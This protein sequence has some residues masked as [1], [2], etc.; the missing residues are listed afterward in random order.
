[1]GLG[2]I[3]RALS[4]APMSSTPE[5]IEEWERSSLLTYS[6]HRRSAADCARE[7]AQIDD[8]FLR[9][10][11]SLGTHGS[12]P[13]A[14]RGDAGQSGSLAAR[15]LARHGASLLRSGD[16]P[17][18]V[19]VFRQAA[20]I[21]PGSAAAW[22]NLGVA[23]DCAGDPGEA[24]T[25]L[26]RSLGLLQAQPASWLQ[27]GLVREKL[28]DPHGAEFAF[29]RALEL[30]PLDPASWQCLALLKTAQGDIPAAIDCYTASVDRGGAGPAVWANL[31]KLCHRIGRFAESHDAYAKAA[32]LE[33]GNEVFRAMERKTAFLHGLLRG[34]TPDEALKA[35]CGTA[36]PRGS[37][38]EAQA[39]SIL[40]T[41][42]GILNGFGHSG[43]ARAAARK[44]LSL[45]PDDTTMRYLADALE[46][47]GPLRSPPDYLV[48]H[49]D[50]FAEHFDAQLVG[51][52]GYDLP[53]QIGSLLGAL[54]AGLRAAHAL[55]A[56]CGTGLCGPI[57]RPFAARLTGVDLSAG[58][59]A[60]AARRGVY[61]ALVQSELLAFLN[62]TPH[63]Y[64]L[65]AAA[66]VL[67]YFGDLTPLFTMAAYALR[68]G[69]LFIAST[70]QTSDGDFRLRSSGRFGHAPGYVQRTARP[71]FIAE[72]V[73][74]TTLRLEGK[75]R[76]AGHLFVFRRL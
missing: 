49:F 42:F 39:R 68:P 7:H 71:E 16:A 48:E 58:M 1:M 70:E 6:A 14:A 51:T 23:L 28:L 31:G 27:L 26:E 55:D 54:P 66:D 15:H 22:T 61:D 29:R 50:R 67:I 44:Y 46:G 8:E 76:I 73:T 75:E 37:G 65:I 21:D 18:A 30:D 47:S 43:A 3:L 64:D 24:S 12:P 38:A 34:S 52:L 2:G 41:A 11:L 45:W 69:G 17:G 53:Q 13:Q 20:A 35:F 57:L 59:L 56:G 19:A 40:E 36:D 62:Q 25:C 32:R 33:P 74:E 9:W 63:E 72:S 4:T 10:Y 60:Q 5:L